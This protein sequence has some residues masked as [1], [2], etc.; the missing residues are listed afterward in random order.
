MRQSEEH[1]PRNKFVVQLESGHPGFTNYLF[2]A[3]EPGLREL[4]GALER[5][6]GLSHGAR[7]D[8]HVTERSDADSMGALAFAKCS[9]EKLLELQQP[10]V[11]TKFK[12][13]YSGLAGT[14]LLVIIFV[15][16]FVHCLRYLWQLVN[17]AVGNG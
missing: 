13:L 17:W 4:S 9:E 6:A 2:I 14:G 12:R 1:K 3:A 11:A 5:L 8:F 15:V 7:I 10:S 16:G